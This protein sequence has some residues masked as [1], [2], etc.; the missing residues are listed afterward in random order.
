LNE[1]GAAN[2]VIVGDGELRESLLA[3]AEELKIMKHV[4]FT[5]FIEKKLV[6]ELLKKSHV[7]L[8]TSKVEGWPTALVEALACGLPAVST[9]VSGATE[10]IKNG[11]NGFIVNERDPQIFARFM[12]FAIDLGPINFES[13]QA[14][15]S[16]RVSGMHESITMMF[17][18][19]FNRQ[20]VNK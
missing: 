6:A 20:P 10:M 2:L 9:A 17:P 4:T 15:E 18:N 5:G 14:V 12:R 1:Y 3:Y 7:F 19:F 11:V 13:M 8:L 16:Y